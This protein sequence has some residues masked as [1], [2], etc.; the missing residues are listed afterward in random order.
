V[1]ERALEADGGG[2]LFARGAHLLGDLA[3]AR[4][5]VRGRASPALNVQC[6]KL[7][8]GPDR[9]PAANMLPNR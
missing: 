3:P 2:Q 8:H 5:V 6:R 9:L 7:A 1:V 4:D